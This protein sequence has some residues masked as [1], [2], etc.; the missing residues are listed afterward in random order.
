[1]VFSSHL[2]SVLFAISFTSKLVFSVR[3]Y[4]IIICS[5]SFVK[6]YLFP[7]TKAVLNS[8]IILDGESCRKVDANQCIIANGEYAKKMRAA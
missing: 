6:N 7:L 4:A 3:F 8:I 1:M 5:I 2:F